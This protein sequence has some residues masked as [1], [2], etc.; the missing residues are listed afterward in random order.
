MVAQ[1]GGSDDIMGN[2]TTLFSRCR[3]CAVLAIGLAWLPIGAVSSESAERITL[4]VGEQ[5]VLDA[6]EVA[7]FSEST[8]G[9]IEVKVPR[10]GGSLVVTALRQGS[11]SLLLLGSG[12]AKRT[13]HF[14]VFARA[15]QAIEV[16]LRGLLPWVRELQV[17]R[18]GSRLFLEGTVTSEGELLRLERVVKLYDGQV[19]SLI[20]LDPLVVAHRTNIRL[21][22]LFVGLRRSSSL[23]GGVSWPTSFGAGGVLQ[24]SVD[25]MSGNLAA[26]Y[27]IV[28]QALPSVE[29]A[30]RA[31]WAKI[32]KKVAVLTTSGH[33]ASYEAGGE[34]NI[35]VAGSQA[36]ELRTVP[37]GARLSVLPRLDAAGERL[38]IEVEAEI[39]DL[40]ETT[41]DVPGRMVS[42]VSTLVHLCAG[43]SI[44]LGGLDS[45][46]HSRGRSGLPGLSRVPVFGMLFGIH[47]RQDQEEE[48]LIFITPTVVENLDAAGRDELKR[49]VAKYRAYIGR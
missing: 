23:A 15:P 44:V 29:A 1:E 20:G 12:D 46:H 26:S 9:V 11:T 43:Q 47:S 49:A 27:S 13:L 25:L 7:S 35:A 19:I 17:R 21:D 3:W 8:R 2:R 18:L 32:R 39:S 42:R 34:V 24:G 16:E 36:A 41:Q 37:Y 48:G 14:D 4:A 22:L 45:N 31:G 33:K 38:D 5:K 10:T 30:S 6:A 28:N 40:T